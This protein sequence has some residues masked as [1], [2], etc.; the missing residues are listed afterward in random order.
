MPWPVVNSVFVIDR[1]M[2]VSKR[3]FEVT[4]EPD[5]LTAFLRRDWRPVAEAASVSGSPTADDEN[6]TSFRRARSNSL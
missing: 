2:S 4:N 5:P 1:R 3:L 6:M